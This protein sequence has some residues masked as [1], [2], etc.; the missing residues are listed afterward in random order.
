METNRC[1][2][3]LAKEYKFYLAFENS[4]CKDYIS[5]KFFEKALGHDVL[6]IVMGAPPDDYE[7][8]APFRSY[9]HVEH[10]KSP[11]ELAEYLHILDNNDD[12][13]NTYFKWKGTGEFLG[14]GPKTFCRLC[15]L[16]HDEH[17]TSIGHWYKNIN[18]WW[19]GPGICTKGFWRDFDIKNSTM[20]FWYKKGNRQRMSVQNAVLSTP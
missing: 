11:K 12:F 17:A 16:L 8:Y 15:A 7:K 13:Y 4:N 18:D 20:T 19:R 5:E 10:F 2:D 14:G 6:P 9:I 3:R 1:D